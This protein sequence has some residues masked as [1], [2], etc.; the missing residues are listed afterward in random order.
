MEVINTLEKEG[1]SGRWN[2][3]WIPLQ[4]YRRCPFRSRNGCCRR[5]NWS[6]S[7]FGFNHSTW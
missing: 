7:Y 4:L 6:L 3:M 5:M 1:L 2:N